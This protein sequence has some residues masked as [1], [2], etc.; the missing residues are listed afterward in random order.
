MLLS[1][2]LF[3]ENKIQS[4]N[5]ISIRAKGGASR[6]SSCVKSR[7]EPQERKQTKNESENI[8]YMTIIKLLVNNLFNENKIKNKHKIPTR[9]KGGANRPSC[10]AK[11]RIE[12]QEKKQTKKESD[13]IKQK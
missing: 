2:N 5:N 4:K 9:A 10:C 1:N 7:I 11:S 6:P 12:L 8:K 13:N 3:N